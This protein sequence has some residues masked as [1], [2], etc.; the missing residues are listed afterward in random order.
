MTF[1]DILLWTVIIVASVPVIIIAGGFVIFFLVKVLFVI[2]GILGTLIAVAIGVCLFLLLGELFG[3][4]PPGTF[5]A[6]W[7][8][9]VK[10]LA[11]LVDFI[12]EARIWK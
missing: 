6:V 10:E 2:G 3:F 4:F 11:L 1:G 7:D 9:S 12:N 8:E 5:S